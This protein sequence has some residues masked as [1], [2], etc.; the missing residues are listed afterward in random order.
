M[1]GV[2]V[3]FT[4]TDVGRLYVY[5]G[6]FEKLDLGKIPRRSPRI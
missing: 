1:T 6:L 5:D 3:E 4:T 2:Q